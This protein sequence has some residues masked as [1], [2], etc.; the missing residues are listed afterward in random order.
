MDVCTQIKSSALAHLVVGLEVVYLLVE[1]MD[2]ELLTNEHNSI[3][4]VLESRLISRHSL[5]Q[6]LP[7]SL[8]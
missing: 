8:S 4:F 7:H 1:C 6:T 5:H 2:P 3:Q